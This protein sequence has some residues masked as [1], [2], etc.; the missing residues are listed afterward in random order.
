MVGASVF[1]KLFTLAKIASLL[2]GVVSSL[3]LPGWLVVMVI[4]TIFLIVGCFMETL[5]VVL[6]TL[7]IFL[8][9]LRSYGY[10]G[11]WYG[12]FNVLVAGLGAITPPV[13]MSCYIVSGITGAPL[14]KVFKGSFPFIIPFMVMILIMAIWPQTVTWLPSLVF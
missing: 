8:P 5:P 11:I 3:A 6:V 4:G 1:G 12:V 14:Q 9:I 13:G 2:N 10:S 7:P